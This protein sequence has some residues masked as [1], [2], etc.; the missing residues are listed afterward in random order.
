[1]PGAASSPAVDSAPYRMAVNSG[2]SIVDM[3]WHDRT[4]ATI[5]TRE[6]FEDAAARTAR[7]TVKERVLDGSNGAPQAG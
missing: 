3:V 5:L 2:K 7:V 4:P 1:M 6:A